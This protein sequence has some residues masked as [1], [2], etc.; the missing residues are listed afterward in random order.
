MKFCEKCG[1]EIM[2]EAVVCPN[3]GCAVGREA[4]KQE[5][6]YDDCVKK[7]ATTNIISVV[8]IAVAVICWLFVNMWVGAILC[9]VAEFIAISSNSK[10]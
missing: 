6:S 3:C 2:E 10:V 1:N 4:K 7:A 8:V 9:L 5:V